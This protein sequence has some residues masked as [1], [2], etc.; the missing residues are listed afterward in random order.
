MLT[1]LAPPATP[2]VFMLAVPDPKAVV[3]CPLLFTVCSAL[4]AR[5][6]AGCVT[7]STTAAGLASGAV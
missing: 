2:L 3:R 7:L 4:V 1:R 6:S 5:I